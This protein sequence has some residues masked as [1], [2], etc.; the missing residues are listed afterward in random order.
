MASIFIFFT[1]L[2]IG[3][4]GFYVYNNEKT[5]WKIEKNDI[6]EFYKIAKEQNHDNKIK[7]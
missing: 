5:D 3:I 4:L 2:I 6:K 7:I 1:G